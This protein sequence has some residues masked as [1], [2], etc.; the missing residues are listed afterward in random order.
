M[1]QLEDIPKKQA[2]KVP[3]RYFDEL[4]LRIQARIEAKKPA[5]AATSTNFSK[6]MLRYALPLFAIGVVGM[7][8]W[9]EQSDQRGDAVAL[10][11]NISSQELVAFLEDEGITTDDVLEQASLNDIDLDNM[12][13]PLDN[14]STADLDDLVNEFDINL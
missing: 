11:N 4:P 3:D 12:Q 1:V 14:I 8:L 10:L 5:I 13:K 9:N 6:L 7:L 2:F